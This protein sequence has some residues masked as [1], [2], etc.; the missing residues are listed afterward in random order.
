M[1]NLMMLLVLCQTFYRLNGGY[2]IGW[3]NGI[4][5]RAFGPSKTT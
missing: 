2:G 4:E 3:V 5:W 1:I